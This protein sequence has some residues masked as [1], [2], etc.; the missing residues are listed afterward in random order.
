MTE[1]I[2]CNLAEAARGRPGSLARALALTQ[3]MHDR[4]LSRAPKGG[5]VDRLGED[6][7]PIGDFMPA[8]SL[9][10]L[11]GS[12]DELSGFSAGGKP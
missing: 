1:A 6:G 10:H 8:T 12:V 3:S 4:F 11:V 9:Y 5:W 7:T 2:K